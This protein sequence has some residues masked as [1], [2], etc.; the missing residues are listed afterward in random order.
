[1]EWGIFYACEKIT[2]GLKIVPNGNPR[3]NH[4]N[5]DSKEKDGGAQET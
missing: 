2:G 4:T 3:Q 5:G 1:M